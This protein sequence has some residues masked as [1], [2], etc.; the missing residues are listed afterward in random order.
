MLVGSVKADSSHACLMPG[1]LHTRMP[2]DQ[3][4]QLNMAPSQHV[5]PEILSGVLAERKRSLPL[6]PDIPG[7]SP[8]QIDARPHNWDPSTLSLLAD[9]FKTVSIHVRPR[10]RCWYEMRPLQH[11]VCWPNG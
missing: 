4:R 2:D 6:G 8:G 10:P 9:N 7:A 1:V 11:L 5:D 3:H